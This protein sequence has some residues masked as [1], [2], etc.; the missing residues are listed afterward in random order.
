VRKERGRRSGE[1]EGEGDGEI[2]R[3]ENG[4]DVIRRY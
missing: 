4:L 1:G 2:G 3:L